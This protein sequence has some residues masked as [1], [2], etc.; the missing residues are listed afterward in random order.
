MPARE[1]VSVS[2]DSE[3]VAQARRRVRRRELSAYLN[4][5][6][7]RRLQADAIGA[8]LRDAASRVGDVP[9]GVGETVDRAWNDRFRA[10][11]L[12]KV[13]RR[14]AHALGEPAASQAHAEAGEPPTE[15]VDLLRLLERTT[16]QHVPLESVVGSHP[17]VAVKGDTVT[18]VGLDPALDAEPD[19]A[20]A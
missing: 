17:A 15:S 6:L 20:S 10:A 7:Q 12:T 9:V 1:K 2:L 11:R 4:E 18:I 14:I 8:Y 16:T 5:A 19:A 3:L 13:R